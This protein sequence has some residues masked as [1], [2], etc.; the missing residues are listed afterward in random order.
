MRAP[1]PFHRLQSAPCGSR[2]PPPRA[3]FPGKNGAALRRDVAGDLDILTVDPDCSGMVNVTG[4]PHHD[5]RRVRTK[6]AS[7]AGGSATPLP[8][9]AAQRSRTATFARRTSSSRCSR[10]PRRHHPRAAPEAVERRARL[11]R[12][13]TRLAARVLPQRP[14]PSSNRSRSRA[15]QRIFDWLDEPLAADGSPTER[16]R[17][18]GEV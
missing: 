12:G 8:P 4:D 13:A 9:R 1:G 15:E 2:R 17:S 3:T 18:D 11:P 7:R 16:R 6:N 14:I 5:V 10:T